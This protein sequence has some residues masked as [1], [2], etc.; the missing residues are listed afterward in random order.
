[1]SPRIET[2]QYMIKADMPCQMLLLLVFQI[3]S[4]HMGACFSSYSGI[5]T[6]RCKRG[7]FHSDFVGFDMHAE[8]LFV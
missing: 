2:L 5:P 4:G 7:W 3:I 6:P 1:M 8:S